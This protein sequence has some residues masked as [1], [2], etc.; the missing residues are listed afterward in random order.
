MKKNYVVVDFDPHKSGQVKSYSDL[1]EALDNTT[2]KKWEFSGVQVHKAEF[3]SLKRYLAY[4]KHG[5][6]LFF[7][8][9]QIEN[10][11]SFQQFYGLI[12]ALYCR[13]WGV[14]KTTKVC[15]LSFI[16]KPKNGFVGKIYKNFIK[17][18]VNSKY[19]D[20]LLV[21]STKEIEFYAKTLNINKSKLQFVPLGIVDIGMG[22]SNSYKG[23]YILSAGNSNRDFNFVENAL[24][25]KPY[26]VEIYSDEY[27]EHINQ[28]VQCKK[29]LPTREYL[30]KLSRCFCVV[31]ALDN[32]NISSGQL[33]MLQSYALGKPLII[34]KTKGCKEYI[35]EPIAISIEKS[36]EALISAVEKLKNDDV[37]YESCSRHGRK[38]FEENFS[39]KS[40]GQQIGHIFLEL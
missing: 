22:T 12:F 18:I 39:L 16:Y 4:F 23:D 31:I 26:E 19:I 20:K 27:Y 40:M 24:V 38:T 34:T 14:K 2:R 28:N 6:T 5:L 8:R 25:G 29:G 15:I 36:E 7:E 3:H 9:K 32:P 33:V 17:Y 10:L 11:L 1:L 21:H 37:Y 13:L 35:K 30:E